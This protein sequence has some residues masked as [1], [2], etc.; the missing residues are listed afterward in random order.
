[1][2]VAGETVLRDRLS[3]LGFMVFWLGCFGFTV[4]AIFTALADAR[5]LRN[6]SRNQQRALFEETLARIRQNKRP[7]D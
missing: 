1:M 3:S 6:E 5:A 7:R 4:L 2:L